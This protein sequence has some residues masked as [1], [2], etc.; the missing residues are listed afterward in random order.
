MRACTHMCGLYLRGW[1]VYDELGRGGVSLA[2]VVLVAFRVDLHFLVSLILYS[3][4]V[5]M[6]I[7]CFDS[8]FVEIN[9]VS[10]E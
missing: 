4:G 8:D 1:L 6:Y 10:C 3:E 5:S 7:V 9:H 2:V